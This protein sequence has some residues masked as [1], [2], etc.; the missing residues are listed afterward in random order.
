[1]KISLDH[2]ST[3][4][5]NFGNFFYNKVKIGTNVRRK[6]YKNILLYPISPASAKY[7]IFDFM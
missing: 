5:K 1:M 4:V 2:I 7:L 3:F 6:Q